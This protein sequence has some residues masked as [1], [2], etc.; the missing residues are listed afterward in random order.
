MQDVHWVK[1]HRRNGKVV[2]GHWR[3]NPKLRPG[4]TPYRRD[5]ASRWVGVGAAGF[6]GLFIAYEVLVWVLR[7]WWIVLLILVI[8]G[9]ASVWVLRSRRLSGAVD[10]A[11]HAYDI[12]DVD[13]AS[14]REFEAVIGDL[15]QRDG[16]ISR[17][18]GGSN[19]M[20]VD[21]IG[22]SPTRGWVLAVQ[23]KHTTTDRK[24]T[25]NVL[26]Q[27]CGTAASCYHAT[28]QIVVTNGGFTANALAWGKDPDHQVHLIDRAR[29]TAW[30]AGHPIAEL[31]SRTH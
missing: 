23:C 21:V 22:S 12:T 16:F 13:L 6:V 8:V 4:R 24:I 3:R 27:I 7:H 11:P 14:P 31:I 15:L 10:D 17:L 5:D 29:L 26:Y 2:R 18:V 28:H 1:R 25:P 30:L 20:A 9:A 19:D